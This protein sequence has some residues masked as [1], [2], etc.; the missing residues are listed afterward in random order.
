MLETAEY[1]VA[2][3]VDRESQ[4]WVVRDP[5]GNFWTLPTTHDAWENRLPFEPLPNNT[6]EPIPGHYKY[7]LGLPF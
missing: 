1:V 6:L 7:T 3:Y 4:Q 2:L 5:E